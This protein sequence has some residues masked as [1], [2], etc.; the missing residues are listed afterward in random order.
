MLLLKRIVSRENRLA[1]LLSL[2]LIA[3]VVCTATSSPTWI[4]QGF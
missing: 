4:Y 3:L 1:L 2:I